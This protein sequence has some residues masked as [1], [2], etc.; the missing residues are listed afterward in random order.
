MREELRSLFKDGRVATTDELVAV[1]QVS[2]ISSRTRTIRTRAKR[3]GL[4][5]QMIGYQAWILDD[6]N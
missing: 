3:L 5:I 2:D 4:P 6:I 1:L